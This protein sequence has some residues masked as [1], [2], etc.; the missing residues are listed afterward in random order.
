MVNLYEGIL[1][2]V[3]IWTASYFVLR[4]TLK[5]DPGKGEKVRLYPLFIMLRTVKFTGVLD[6]LS[7]KRPVVWDVASNMGISTALGLMVLAVYFLARNLSVFL[8]TPEEAGIQNVVIPLVPFVTISVN[9]IPYFLLAVA[10]VLIV[11]EGMHGVIARREKVPI[12]SSGVFLLFLLAG[13]FVEPDEQEFKKSSPKTRM[14]VSAAGSFANIVLGLIILS[15]L[16]V[17]FTFPSPSGVVV[18][19]ADE[20]NTYGL[21]AYE[22]LTKVGQLPLQSA[23]DLQTEVS[24][25]PG[26]VLVTGKN[27]NYLLEVDKPYEGPLSGLI[28][29]LG[30]REIDF[31]FPMKLEVFDT[32]STYILY[33]SLWWIWL[34]SIGVGIF[35]ML[36]LFMLD[37]DLFLRALLET[38]IVSAKKVEVLSRIVSTGSFVLLFSNILFSYFNFGLFQI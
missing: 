5:R 37:G 10:A 19:R 35:N 3:V 38:K 9:S 15:V 33:K 16:V 13:G 1:L 36:P 17:G 12:K 7:N 25:Q 2:A 24:V 28:R 8:V 20:T 6:L 21:Q 27:K 34:I 29:S 22:V 14:K 30:V 26:K 18:V 4:L 32:A 31:Y 11:H 23:Q